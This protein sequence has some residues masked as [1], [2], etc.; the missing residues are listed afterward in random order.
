MAEKLLQ[1]DG[2]RGDVDWWS[3]FE[4]LDDRDAFS[5]RHL[6]EDGGGASLPK[7]DVMDFI[8]ELLAEEV[9]KIYNELGSG[10][11]RIIF[12]G[13][14]AVAEIFGMVIR[15]INKDHIICHRALALRFYRDAFKQEHSAGEPSYSAQY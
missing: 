10:N 2:L 3:C 15:F 5:I 8:P 7:R 11:F 14:P 13:T 4:L 12:D 9:K 1:E 6:L